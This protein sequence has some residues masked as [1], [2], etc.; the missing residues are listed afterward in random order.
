MFTNDLKPSALVWIPSP[1]PS[2]ESKNPEPFF[3]A[4]VLSY[5]P[6]ALTYSVEPVDPPGEAM[7]VPQTDVSVLNPRTENGVE[8]MVDLE[9]L[10]EAELLF[11]IKI[12][13]DKNAIFT[14]VGPTLIALNPYMKIPELFD[15]ETMLGIQRKSCG[16][17][18][19]LKD[20]K[21]HIFALCGKVFRQ[22]IE[23]NKNQAIV[24][25]GESGAGKTE[26][27]KYAMSFI[28][29]ICIVFFLGC[30]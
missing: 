1:P 11:N 2:K 27:T 5:D 24:I 19:E 3:L 13:F 7:Q 9:N 16:S 28:T 6:Q 25:S 8:D 18:F 10:N 14:Y 20:L 17:S 30:N 26:E 29:S 15:G 21:P 4:K 23:N 22:L 12:R